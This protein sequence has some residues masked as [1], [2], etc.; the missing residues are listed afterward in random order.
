MILIDD[1]NNFA[2]HHKEERPNIEASIF[3]SSDDEVSKLIKDLTNANDKCTLITVVPSHNPNI[4]DEDTRQ[5]QNQLLFFV[6]K[7]YD[8]KAGNNEKIKNFSL[9]QVEVQQLVNKIIDLKDNPSGLCDFSDID[10]NSI[11]ITPVSNYYNQNGYLMQL[12]S[13]TD[14]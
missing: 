10:Y 11:Q 14:F 13:R 1:L 9:C 6:V 8:S 7:K 4:P 5:M 12:N 2:D 3:V